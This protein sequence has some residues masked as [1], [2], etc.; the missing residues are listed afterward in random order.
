MSQ[1][2][3]VVNNPS[4]TERIVESKR[5]Q[6]EKQP[7]EKYT[8]EDLKRLAEKRAR[9]AQVLHRGI[10]NSR[11]EIKDP[12]PSKHYEFVRNRDEDIERSLALGFEVEK[13]QG[14]GLHDKGDSR[15]VIGDVILM[16]ISKEDFAVI[17][18]YFRE[19]KA[20]KSALGKKEYLARSKMSRPDVP[21]LDPLGVGRE[22]T[23]ED[24]ENAISTS[25]E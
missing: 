14:K 2:R 6:A 11:L 3:R 9:I 23:E 25:A 16:S 15:H 17:E 20:A 12:D 13:D 10:I 8:D 5:E 19:V 7:V 22:M 18:D 1:G 4:K 24:Y 21:I